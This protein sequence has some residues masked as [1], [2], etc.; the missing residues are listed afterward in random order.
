MAPF[1]IVNG[2]KLTQN[3][4]WKRLNAV[5]HNDS[6]QGFMNRFFNFLMKSKCFLDSNQRKFVKDS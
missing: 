1:F 6:F 5:L 4:A 2:L 3:V